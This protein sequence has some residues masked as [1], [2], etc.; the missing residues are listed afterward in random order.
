MSR[1]CNAAC[2]DLVIFPIGDDCCSVVVILATPIVAR[3]ASAFVG[4]AAKR[5][6]PTT[7]A[8]A[9]TF[10]L[11]RLRVAFERQDIA[12]SPV[13]GADREDGMMVFI[14]MVCHA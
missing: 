12:A 3:S 7:P 6:V 8:F 11:H 4:P 1:T 10:D 14:A 2:V 9:R 5:V 13:A